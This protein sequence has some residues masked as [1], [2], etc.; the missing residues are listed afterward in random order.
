MIIEEILDMFDQ[1][2]KRDNFIIGWLQKILAMFD[3]AV[4]MDNLIVA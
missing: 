3:Q 2:V 4:K 1:V